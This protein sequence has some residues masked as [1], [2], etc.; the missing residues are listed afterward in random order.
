[1]HTTLRD[2]D[3]AYDWHAHA[4]PWPEIKVAIAL[5]ATVLLAALLLF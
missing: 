1:M 4:A 3:G 2:P 5:A